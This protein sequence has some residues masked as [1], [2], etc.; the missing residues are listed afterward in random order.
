MTIHFAGHPIQIGS[1]VRQRCGWCGE[2]LV[3]DEDLAQLM[4][5]AGS[6][7]WSPWDTGGL[8]LKDGAVRGVVAH[9][10]GKPLPTGT[11]ADDLPP[12]KPA[13]RRVK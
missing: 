8:V 7:P 5:P 11:C 1:R 2:I 12:R 3:E 6:S 10:D 13:L 9:T 4:A